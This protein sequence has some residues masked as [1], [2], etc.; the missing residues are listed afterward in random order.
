MGLGLLDE[1][2]HA[3]AM[4]LGLVRV[5]HAGQHVAQGLGVFFDPCN[6]VVEHLGQILV[7]DLARHLLDH[8][9]H[10]VVGRHQILE[11]FDIEI[12]EILGSAH[13]CSFVC[14][15]LR[16]NPATRVD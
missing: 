15:I 4:L 10:L 9:F 7:L 8:L 12:G 16:A 6:R 3:L 14:R 11:F 13:K 1:A 2:F 5:V